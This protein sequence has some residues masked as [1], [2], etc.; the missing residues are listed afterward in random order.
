MRYNDK[1]YIEKDDVQEIII[2]WKK[3]ATIHPIP[4]NSQAET[5]ADGIVE[6]EHL[7]L[8]Q[9]QVKEPETSCILDD[10][11]RIP[12]DVGDYEQHTNDK[13]VSSDIS[14]FCHISVLR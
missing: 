4:T 8:P 6:Y 3:V 14:I 5:V 2:V 12:T 11:L 10:N 1:W 13:C 7:M 9:T